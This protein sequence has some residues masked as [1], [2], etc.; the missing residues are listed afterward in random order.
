MELARGGTPDGRP[1][2]I[3][4]AD[5]MGVYREMDIGTAKPSAADRSEIPHWCLDLVGPDEEYTVKRYQR[6]AKAALADIAGR[7]AQALMVGGAGLYIRAVVDD[8]EMPGQFPQVR[9]E[10]DATSSTAELYSRLR[11]SD[12]TAAGRMEPTNRRRILR[13]LEVTLGS[14]KRFSEFGAG[15]TTYPPT[16]F[17]QVGLRLSRPLMNERIAARLEQQLTAGLVAEAEQLFHRPGG[18]SKTARQALAYKE[19]FDHF[20]GELSLPEA[21]ELALARTRRFS[22]RQQRWFKRDPR[23]IWVEVDS[24]AGTGADADT[25]ADTDIDTNTDSK[26]LEAMTETVRGLL[27]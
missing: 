17:R 6:D 3:V 2:E 19:L 25:G 4:S 12:P 16:G 21:V 13:A 8:I 11:E 14:G 24:P 1:I 15:L 7:G 10:L 27:F 22:R 18:L 23:I 26:T 5:S 20:K 9:Q